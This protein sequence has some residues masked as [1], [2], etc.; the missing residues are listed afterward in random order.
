MNT[1]EVIFT[2]FHLYTYLQ[3]NTHI[4]LYKYFYLILFLY[5]IDQKFGFLILTK[6]AFILI[7]NT[8]KTVAL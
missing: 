7:K 1:S 5:T 4:C 3:I 2:R 8:V 6:A